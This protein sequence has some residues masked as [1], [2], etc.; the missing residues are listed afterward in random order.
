MHNYSTLAN[1][2]EVGDQLTVL[3]IDLRHIGGEARTDD[4]LGLCWAQKCRPSPAASGRHI[5]DRV[6]RACPRKRAVGRLF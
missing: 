2:G 5:T 6:V 4:A 1:C 3:R